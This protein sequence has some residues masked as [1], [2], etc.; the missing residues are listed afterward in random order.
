M[1]SRVFENDVKIYGIQTVPAPQRHAVI[2]WEWCKDIWY[3]NS[4]CEKNA[5]YMFENGVK[6]YGIQTSTFTTA[7]NI[8]F[9]NDVKIYGIQTLFAR[10]AHKVM[11]ENDV[12]IYGIQTHLPL[13][14]PAQ[15]LRMM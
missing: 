8:A 11:F 13:Q 5:V 10:E 15:S 7:S 3:S 2:V 9:E 1:N 6:I 12:K 14:L 4:K